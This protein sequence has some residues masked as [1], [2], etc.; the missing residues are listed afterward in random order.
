MESQSAMKSFQKKM[1]IYI[2]CFYFLYFIFLFLFLFIFIFIYFQPEN[3]FLV[4]KVQAPLGNSSLI[5]F[6]LT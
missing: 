6:F 4:E 1:S 2:Y 5:L 3:Y